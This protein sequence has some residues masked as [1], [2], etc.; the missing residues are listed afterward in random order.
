MCRYQNLS[1]SLKKTSI[2]PDRFEFVRINVSKDGNRPTMSKHQLVEHW[3]DPT[4]VCEILSLIGFAIFYSS[5]IPL[6][7][8]RVSRLHEITKLES[9]ETVEPH[10]DE[11][12]R[13]EWEDIKE[14]LLSDPCLAHYDHTQRLYL[15]MGMRS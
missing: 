7:E 1:L 9:T 8:T 12:A 6:F 11:S 15:R 14:A 13:K 2:F 3:P 5:F 4:I 10:F